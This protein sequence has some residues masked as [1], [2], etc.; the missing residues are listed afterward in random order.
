MIDKRIVFSQASLE[1]KSEVA[2]IKHTSRA[3]SEGEINGAA[4]LDT[5]SG[6]ALLSLD[7]FELLFSLDSCLLLTTSTFAE[8]FTTA[9][10]VGDFFPGA[11]LPTASSALDASMG[12]PLSAT[13][14]CFA[15]FDI[16]PKD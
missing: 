13:T 4:E 12:K 15:F 7:F 9:D 3:S 6:V 16:V 8:P 5:C 1:S 11:T 10:A 14:A 2:S